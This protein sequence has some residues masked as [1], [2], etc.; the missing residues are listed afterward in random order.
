MF[1]RRLLSPLGFA[2]SGDFYAFK[3]F[4]IAH[5]EAQLLLNP[6]RRLGSTS[7]AGLSF[8]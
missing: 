2:V 3:E 8:D 5:A 4:S 6:S 7:H 1:Y